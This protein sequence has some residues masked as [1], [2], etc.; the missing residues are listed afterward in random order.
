MTDDL[1]FGLE[2]YRCFFQQKTAEL[3]LQCGKVIALV[4][5]NNSGKSAFIRS[6]YEL[7]NSLQNIG[8][9]PWDMVSDGV[10]QSPNAMASPQFQG[11]QDQLDV[12]PNAFFSKDKK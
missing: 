2:S 7:R 9:G 5:P 11:V 12:V 3:H 6:I 1:Y 4:G 10:F 8:L